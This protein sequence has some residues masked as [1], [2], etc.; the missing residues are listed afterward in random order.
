[1][2]EQF[3]RSYYA[4]TPDQHQGEFYIGACNLSHVLNGPPHPTPNSVVR[5]ISLSELARWIDDR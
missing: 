5:V 4:I 3:F 2:L 1:M